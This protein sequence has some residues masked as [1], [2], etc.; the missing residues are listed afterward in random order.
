MKEEKIFESLEDIDEK[1]VV[2]ARNKEGKKQTIWV[3][4]AAVAACAVI[5]AAV[6]LGVNAIKK[7]G[8]IGPDISQ[9]SSEPQES[10][11]ENTSTSQA[12]ESEVSEQESTVEKDPFKLTAVMATYPDP[13]APNMS[14]EKFFASQEHREWNYLRSANIQK[15][16]EFQPGMSGYYE[17][18]MKQLLVSEDENTVCSPLNTYIAFAMLAEVTDGSTRQQILDMLEI[19]DIETLRNNVSALWES[20]YADTP[21]IKSVLGNSLW[22]RNDFDYKPDT[23]S[24]LAENYYA[25]SFSGAPGSEEMDQAL[26]KW[27]D[28]NTGGLLKEYTDNMK[29]DPDMI[30]EIVSTIYYKAQ[31]DT[32]F[33]KDETT[34][35]IFH[36]SLGD[37]TVDMMNKYCSIKG[38]YMTDKFAALQR[39]IT[40]GGVMYFIL[41]NEGVDVNELLSDPEVLDIIYDYDFR[42]E[43]YTLWDLYISVPK[44]KVSYKTNLTEALKALG[45]TELFDAS[46]DFSPLTE[47]AEGIYFSGASHTAM[48]E[49]DEDG[50]TGAAYTE[51]EWGG[52]G[53]D[54]QPEEYHFVLDRP[55]AFIL[56][57]RDQSILFSGIVRNID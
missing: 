15:S 26:Q 21:S 51:L 4:W 16:R 30:M 1:Y 27:T 57:S 29:T 14:K 53:L 7:S 39:S 36:G 13:V 40:E 12:S 52:G 41:P 43:K 19:P 48:I 42:N 25:S 28:D 45:V 54:E 31:W 47:N 55:F 8:L 56:T 10:E 11:Q 44:F 3:K 49:I 6:V 23:L 24:R 18:I 38:L 34:R 5:V 32:I 37:T 35:E 2:E 22:L 17:N 33:S 46:A 50:I 9:S 20:N